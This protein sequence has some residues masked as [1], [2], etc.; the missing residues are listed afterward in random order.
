MAKSVVNSSTD[1]GSNLGLGKI[2]RKGVRSDL[3]VSYIQLTI[4][5]DGFA[6][7]SLRMKRNIKMIS[8]KLVTRSRKNRIIE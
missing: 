7:K 6:A 2:P 8:T 1:P 4:G 3:L 5:A